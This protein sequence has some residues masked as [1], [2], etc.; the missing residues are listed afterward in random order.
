MM[1]LILMSNN[2]ARDMLKS[3]LDYNKPQIVVRTYEYRIDE[4]GNKSN[5]S[6]PLEKY[7]KSNLVDFEN[8]L[9]EEKIP[10]DFSEEKKTYGQRVHVTV[11]LN[12]HPF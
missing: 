7:M 5:V 2:V 3:I 6:E 11:H 1:K 8:Y 10:Y 4:E 9:K 12:T